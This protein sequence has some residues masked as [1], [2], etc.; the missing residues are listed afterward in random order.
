MAP[1]EIDRFGHLMVRASAGAGKTFQ[2]S[3]RYLGL[4]SRGVAVEEILASTFTRKAAGE[5]LDRVLVRLAKAA[6]DPADCR[7][8]AQ[9]IGDPSLDRGRAEQLL[10]TLVRKL[11]RLRIS[12]LDSF[13]AQI[14]TSLSLELGLPPGWRIVEQIADERL[15]TEAIQAVLAGDDA[16]STLT[17]LHL[18]T[19]GEAARSVS[20]QI[21]DL[22]NALHGLYLET[23]PEAWKRLPRPQW[24]SHEELEAAMQELADLVLPADKR[25]AKARD[26]DLE[27][28]R[29]AKWSDF[30]SGGIAGAVAAGSASFAGKP[31]DTPVVDVYRRLLQHAKAVLV[32]QLADQTEGAW[33]LLE[34]FDAHYQRLKLA[35]RA[36]RFD[37]VTRKLAGAAVGGQIE[38]LS[39]RLDSRLAHL[40]LD[41][42]QDTSLMQW[43]VVRPFAEAVFAG[44]R[45]RSSFFCVGDVKQAIYG[46]RGGKSELFDELASCWPALAQDALTRSFRS[47]P[48]VIET[49]NRVF[50]RIGDSPALGAFF[51]AAAAWATGFSE[52]ATERQN[53]PGHARLLVGPRAAPGDDQKTTTLIFAAAEIARLAADAPDCSVGALVRDNQA[54]ARLIYELKDR[55]V[56]ASEE[57][58]NPLTDSPA[59]AVVL[60]LLTLADHPG[61]TVARFHVAHSPLGPIVQFENDRD[62]HAAGR[63][64]LAVRRS[65]MNRGYG[66]TIYGWAKALSPACDARDARRVM[67]LVELAYRYE[68]EAT[69]R[70]RD[71]VG[72]VESQ[73]VDDPTSAQVRVMTIHQAKGLEFDIVVLPQLDVQ[74]RGQPPAVVV[75]RPAPTAPANFVCRYAGKELQ[76]LLPPEVRRVF[77]R[78]T[79]QAIRESLCVLYVALTR[80]VHALHMIIAPPTASEKNLPATFA[81]VL[82]SALGDGRPLIE[83]EPLYEQGDAVWRAC[84]VKGSGAGENGGPIAGASAPSSEFHVR[85]APARERRG[86]GLDRQSP[87]GLAAGE[88]ADFAKLLRLDA[89]GALERGTAIHALFERLEWLDDGPPPDAA[90][91]GAVAKLGASPEQAERWLNDFRAMLARPAVRDCLSRREYVR[92]APW[93][94]DEAIR[95]ELAGYAPMLKALRERRFAVRDGNSILTGSVDRLVLVHRDSQLVAAEVLD[96]K[97]DQLSTDRPEQLAETIAGYRPQLAAYRQAVARF[98]GLPVERVFAR[99]LFVEPGLVE[100]VGA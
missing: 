9:F 82:R 72:Y 37:D 12:T 99:L 49:V 80:A 55:G 2:L 62:D 63:L 1:E 67:Q 28:A 91:R 70:T 27:Q 32:G 34:K 90:L 97:T 71:F 87:S 93:A 44:A 26:A 23:S 54:V 58:G 48:A 13:F 35:R 18:L 16:R 89:A 46:W 21:R 73:R 50:R 6:S 19:K 79:D 59:V 7:A 56:Q 65:L 86:R 84:A 83:R 20:D 76:A 24:L 66:P 85:L 68:P 17:L 77:E 33:R 94:E 52:H 10:E 30:I 41:E 88:A 22:V 64:S 39:Y 14:A 92:T 5:I 25:F 74:L 69:L 4:V 8:L 38:Q 3:N 47:A 57:G 78:Q 36:L 29:Q 81:G 95:A 15:R 98:A 11:H 75:G 45:G 96:F 51:D 40:L 53:L 31:L 100:A 42:F 60:A 61:D 43:S